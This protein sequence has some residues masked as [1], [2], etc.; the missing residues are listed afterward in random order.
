[1]LQRQGYAVSTRTSSVEALE[2]FKSKPDEFDMVITDL[3]MP[4]LTGKDL[5]QE[6]MKI[7]PNLPVITCTGFSEEVSGGAA[8]AAGIK[9]FIHKPIISAVLI[10]TV[11]KVLNHQP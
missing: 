6:I 8:K 7:R 5:A 11:Q 3:N 1:M 2:L 4:N 10:A 9:A